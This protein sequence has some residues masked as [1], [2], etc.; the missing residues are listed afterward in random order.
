LSGQEEGEVRYPMNIY[1]GDRLTRPEEV[2]D[3]R[4]IK[5]DHDIWM[6]KAMS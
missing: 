3:E 1:R 4:L 5:A 6:L 2:E